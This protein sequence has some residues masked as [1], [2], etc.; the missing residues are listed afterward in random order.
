MRAGMKSFA[1][2]LL[3]TL[4]GLAAASSAPA[5]TT[6]ASATIKVVCAITTDDSIPAGTSIS[7]SAQAQ[8][9]GTN[10]SQTVQTTTV[11]AKAGSSQR[12]V[13]TLPYKWV[14][15]SPQARVPIFFSASAPTTSG[16]GSV[17]TNLA[18]PMPADGS[19][20]TVSI[21]VRL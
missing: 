8:G 9:A 2:P 13:L 11:T 14:L 17:G 21:P 7:L 16:S 20:V 1:A 6:T 12:I 10:V 19:V 15:A 18:I 4:V 5:E 3:A